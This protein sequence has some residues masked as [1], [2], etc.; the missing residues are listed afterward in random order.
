MT[1]NEPGGG[2]SAGRILGLFVGLIGMAG[3]GLCSLWG[4]VITGREMAREWDPTGLAMLA[5]I[6]PGLGLTALSFLLVRAMI[7]RSRKVPRE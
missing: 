1:T 5:Y 2:W 7:R 6:A 4:I 3:F